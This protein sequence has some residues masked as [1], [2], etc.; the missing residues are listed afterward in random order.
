MIEFKLVELQI[1]EF[2][3]DN[4]FYELAELINLV[5]N[6]IITAINIIPYI[7]GVITIIVFIYLW[8]EE[9]LEKKKRLA[10]R[11]AKRN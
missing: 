6:L 9:K 5:Y 10:T 2:L 3:K 1:V 8:I 4:N 11:K 7:I